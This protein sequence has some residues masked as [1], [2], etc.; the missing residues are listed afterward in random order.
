MI[1]LKNKNMKLVLN[2]GDKVNYQPSHYIEENKFENGI[3]KEIPEHTNNSVRVVYNCAG[4]WEN[5]TEFTSCL[6]NVR[7]LNLGW[8]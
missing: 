7:D 3:V 1:F 5:Y 8:R 4:D 6:T 2:V